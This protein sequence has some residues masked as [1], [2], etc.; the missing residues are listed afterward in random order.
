MTSIL[1]VRRRRIC[2]FIGAGVL[3]RQSFCFKLNCGG[4]GEDGEE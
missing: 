3:P 4:K 2:A 1:L